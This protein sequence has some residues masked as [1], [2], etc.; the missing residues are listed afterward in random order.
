MK[1]VRKSALDLLLARPASEK[2]ALSG[3]QLALKT[4]E[5][6]ERL[7]EVKLVLFRVA[8]EWFGLS[9]SVFSQVTNQKKIHKLPLRK[10]GVILGLVNING[11]LRI[12]ASL[13]MLLGLT[14]AIPQEEKSKRIYP[15]NIV[16]E[17]GEATWVFPVEEVSG[18]ESFQ[19]EKLE[20]VPKNAAFGGITFLKNVVNWREE[21]VGV[22]DEELLFYSL[23]RQI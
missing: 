23:K 19:E 7:P 22:L 6:E 14:H 2:I 12:A 17:R 9:V 10:D 3:C 13:K 15:R 4:A 1:Y 5:A 11:Q 18:I 8:K 20:N 21:R 16:I